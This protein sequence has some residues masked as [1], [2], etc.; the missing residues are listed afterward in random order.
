MTVTMIDGSGD[1][2]IPTPT[3]YLCTRSLPFLLSQL[4]PPPTPKSCILDVLP[5]RICAPSVISPHPPFS[6]LDKLRGRISSRWGL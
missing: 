3:L 5:M 1:D 4:N 2:T 6:S